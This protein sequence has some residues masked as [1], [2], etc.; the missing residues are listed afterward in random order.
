[1][2]QYSAVEAASVI[3]YIHIFLNTED[4]M[5]QSTFF[6]C[7]MVQCSEW[8]SVLSYLVS[9]DAKAKLMFR[10]ESCTRRFK[11]EAKEYTLSRYARRAITNTGALYDAHD[12][13]KRYQ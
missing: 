7:E 12:K 11:Y 1:M 5:G 4:K 6:Y 10:N 2:F 13:S 9:G 3:D 8:K